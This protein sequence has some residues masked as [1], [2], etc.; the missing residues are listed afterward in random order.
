VRAGVASV[1]AAVGAEAA[2][3]A[4]RGRL[5][6]ALLAAHACDDRAALIGLYAEAAEAA[7]PGP[8]AAFYLTHA[9]VYALEAGDARLPALR[10]RLV[11]LGAEP[12]EA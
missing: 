11:D 8:A 2:R 9:Y 4:A 7:G 6:A 10:R 5:D 1:G 3:L 12:A